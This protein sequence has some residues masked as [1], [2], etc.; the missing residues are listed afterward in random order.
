MT[1]RL[2]FAFSVKYTEFNPQCVFNTSECSRSRRHSLPQPNQTTDWFLK[3]RKKSLF[4]LFTLLVLCSYRARWCVAYISCHFIGSCS[5]CNNARDMR[6]QVSSFGSVCDFSLSFTACFLVLS[7]FSTYFALNPLSIYS[8]LYCVCVWVDLSRSLSNRNFRRM[9]HNIKIYHITL[10]LFCAITHT[11][12]HTRFTCTRLKV[13]LIFSVA[14]NMV[15]WVKKFDIFLSNKIAPQRMDEYILHGN[16]FDSL[17]R[18]ITATKFFWR[19]IGI[20]D[21]N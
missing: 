17:K 9:K 10:A 11:H 18:M 16:I 15:F 2:A 6:T 21:R 19:S 20:F 1:A 14:K 3:W 12:M 7:L 4:W 5:F 13:I 8:I